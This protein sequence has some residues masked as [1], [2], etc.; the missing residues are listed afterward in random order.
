VLDAEVIFSR[1]L[2][3][4][5][6]RLATELQL[7]TLIWSEE[8]LEEATAALVERKPVAPEVASRWVGYLRDVAVAAARINPRRREREMATRSRRSGSPD[9]RPTRTSAIRRDRSGR[10]S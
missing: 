10:G 6:A 1:V 3:E 8:L 9:G 4:L 7:L 2:H 5:V